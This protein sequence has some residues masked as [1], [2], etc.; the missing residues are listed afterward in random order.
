M[1]KLCYATS[2]IHLT[3]LTTA[4]ESV[5]LPQSSRDWG[6]SGMSSHSNRVGKSPIL[7]SHVL[8][9]LEKKNGF[10]FLNDL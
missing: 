9:P 1:L 10:F 7:V 5:G 3:L 6:V 4:G 8:F 2:R